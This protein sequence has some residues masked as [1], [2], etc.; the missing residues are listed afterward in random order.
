[1]SSAEQYVTTASES[2]AVSPAIRQ[3]SGVRAGAVVFVGIAAAN[4]GNYAFHLIAAG[5]LHDGQKC[6]QL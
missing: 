2:D 6:V 1:M 3:I 4:I 5:H